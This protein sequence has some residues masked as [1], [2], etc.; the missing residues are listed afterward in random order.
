VD[1]SQ[2]DLFSFLRR[3]VNPANENSFRGRMRDVCIFLASKFKR[4]T[5]AILSFVLYLSLLIGPLLAHVC[6]PDPRLKILAKKWLP[7]ATVS[8]FLCN[9]QAT[10]TMQ[11]QLAALLVALSGSNAFAPI[12]VVKKASTS[13]LAALPKPDDSWFFQPSGGIKQPDFP[14]ARET[15]ES[16]WP[17][18][19]W[20]SIEPTSFVPNTAPEEDWQYKAWSGIGQ[21]NFG[22]PTHT[23]P[24]VQPRT[25]PAVQ[26]AVKERPA[27]QVPEATVPE[28]AMPELATTSASAKIVM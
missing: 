27:E 12:S 13:A 8:Y 10:I 17:Y 20:S 28:P 25:E 16:E 4:T 9:Q 19:A 23:A 24:A 11:F 5:I 3:N 15:G 2:N 6:K 21:S 14:A 22:S 26:K 1:K 7:E 18:R